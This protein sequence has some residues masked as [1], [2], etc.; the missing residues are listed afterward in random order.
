[1]SVAA[2][3]AGGTATNIDMSINGRVCSFCAQGIE[4]TLRSLP[5]T[6]SVK[7]D[8]EQ[9]LVSITLRP[10]G[11]IADEQLRRLIRDAGFDVRQIRRS[12]NG[13]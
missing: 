11:E 12:A 2:V 13:S 7:V 10:G 8:L 5:G 1:I 3:L 9:R 4:R 6:E